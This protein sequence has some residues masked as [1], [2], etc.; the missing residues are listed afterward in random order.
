MLSLR[1]MKI[2]PRGVC[3]DQNVFNIR[4]ASFDFVMDSCILVWQGSSLFFSLETEA[5]Y[6]DRSGSPGKLQ[7]VAGMPGRDAVVKARR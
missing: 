6:A 7:A 2:N 1:G 3:K 5:L 4:V